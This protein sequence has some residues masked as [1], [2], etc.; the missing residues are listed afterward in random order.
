[1]L[2]PTSGNSE[3][4]S[5]EASTVPGVIG[6]IGRALVRR[7]AAAVLA[8]VLVATA[9]VQSACLTLL[10][11]RTA[12]TVRVSETTLIHPFVAED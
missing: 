11:R 10:F 9:C 12:I 2:A 6:E 4:A 5:R 3:T 8:L 1:M 7:R